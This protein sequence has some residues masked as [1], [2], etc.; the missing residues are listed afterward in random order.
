MVLNQKS[1]DFGSYSL[2]RLSVQNGDQEGGPQAPPQRNLQTSEDR[3]G[4]RVVNFSFPNARERGKA[5]V[6]QKI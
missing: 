4:S 1:G 2:P 3:R 6:K 5:K